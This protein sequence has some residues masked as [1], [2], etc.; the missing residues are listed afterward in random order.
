MSEIV[1][2]TAVLVVD[3]DEMSRDLLCEIAGARYQV[4]RA[5]S[6]EEA[7]ELLRGHQIDLVLAEQCLPNMT[8]VE[9]FAAMQK[10]HLYAGRVLITGGLDSAS[11]LVEAINIGAVDKYVKKPTRKDLLLQVI[12]EVLDGRLQKRLAE[13]QDAEK[14]LTQN[15]KMAALGELV[16]GIL[17]EINNPLSY[18]HANLGNLLKF[19]KRLIGLIDGLDQIALS[20]AARAELAGQKEALKYDYLRT[21][22]IE[23]IERSQDGAERM[24]TIIQDYKSFSRA[25]NAG[26]AEAD[27]HAS[28]DTTLSL[29]HHNYKDRIDIKKN[30]GAIP[31]LKCY[32]AKLNQV[33]MNLLVNAIQAIEGPGEIEITTGL[34]GEMAVVSIGDTGCG[35]P[36]DVIE[37]IFDP[38]FTTKPDGVGTGL[39]LS[40][41]GG[42][43]KQHHGQI[44]VESTPG[45][46]TTFTLKMPTYLKP[47][48]LAK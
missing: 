21:R 27:I 38:F 48:D 20:D 28:I 22:I 44:S 45:K 40:I 43:M 3:D 29:L 17:H 32:I 19:N 13:Q 33:F 12:H 46:G 41:L 11:L 35:M 9:L 8:G 15:A 31:P 5:A 30:Y 7:L 2:K 16:A 1:N 25:S 39:G 26:F 23:M 42:I 14:Q 18:I 6:G 10:Q 24:K 47:D 37:K 4:L 34:E 36:P